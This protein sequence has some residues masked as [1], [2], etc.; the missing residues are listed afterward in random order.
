MHKWNGSFSL[1]EFDMKCIL[2]MNFLENDF[3]NL[4]DIKPKKLN[5]TNLGNWSEVENYKYV[6]FLFLSITVMKWVKKIKSSVYWLSLCNYASE[7]MGKTCI[8]FI[9]D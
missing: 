3:V 9:K 4:K 7:S 6:Y 1:W 5:K 2:E 8:R